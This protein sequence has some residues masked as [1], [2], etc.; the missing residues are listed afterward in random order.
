MKIFTLAFLVLFSLIFLSGC[1]NQ[2]SPSTIEPTNIENTDQK[3]EPVVNTDKPGEDTCKNLCGDGVC[4]EI[5]CLAI[6]CPCSETAAS[7]PQDCSNEKTN[8]QNYCDAM[9]Q[10]SAGESCI[11][12]PDEEK[13]I[14]FSGDPCEKCASKNCLVAESYP[15]QVFCQ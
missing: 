7:C 11:K 2:T 1:I 13:P 6:G 15:E 12:F 5:V 4:Q 10:C 14:C 9:I 3:E 8:N